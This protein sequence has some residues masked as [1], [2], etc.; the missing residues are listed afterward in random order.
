[1]NKKI[2]R[3]DSGT[4]KRETVDGFVFSVVRKLP[5]NC[6]NAIATAPASAPPKTP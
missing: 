1:V 5:P 3:E 2:Q 6:G 4:K